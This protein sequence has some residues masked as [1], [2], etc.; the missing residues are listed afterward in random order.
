[1][2]YIKG[3]VGCDGSGYYKL[4]DWHTL[5]RGCDYELLEVDELGN[6]YV[7]D[8]G[9]FLDNEIKRLTL[10]SKPDNVLSGRCNNNIT[11]EIK[12]DT[13]FITGDGDIPDF[14][15]DT[16]WKKETFSKV[17]IGEGITHIG[18][19]AFEGCYSLKSINIPESVQE[20]GDSVFVGCESLENITIPESV[21]YI[22]DY[23]FEG[24]VSL[25]NINIPE[26]VQEIGD[27]VFWECDNLTVHTTRGSTAHRYAY[28]ND[29]KVN[30][31]DALKKET[32][33]NKGYE[34]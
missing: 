1:M 4:G 5:Q 21:T 28:D 33:K 10:I 25:E 34:R 16:E 8:T 29:I 18:D 13:L 2:E 3:G 6:E 24:C 32:K 23:A 30:L 26:S 31:I 17:V 27:Y 22:G 7:S 14:F 11:W 19:Y 20:I 15:D 12:D 9:F